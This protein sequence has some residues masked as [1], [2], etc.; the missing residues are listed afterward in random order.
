[1]PEGRESGQFLMPTLPSAVPLDKLVLFGFD[2]RAFPFQSSVQTHLIPGRRPRYVLK[3]GPEGSH[4]PVILY[5]GTVILIGDTFHMWYN[6]N[7]GPT[8]RKCYERKNCVICY[9]TSKD[10]VNWEKPELGLVEFNGSKKNNIVDL[11]APTLWSTCAVMYEPED[12][13]PD[14]RFKMVYEIGGGIENV[15]FSPDGLR[16]TVKG[17]IKLGIEM[18]GLIK[19]RGVYY[20]NGHAGVLSHRPVPGRRLTTYAS[21][22]FE[23]WSPCGVV[24]L[25]RTHDLSGPST[26]ADAHQYEEIHLGAGLWNR[27]NVIIGLYGQW[28]GHF[29]GDR[30]R[31]G[32]DIGLALSYDA[33][34]FH[35]PI[36]DFRFIP[37]REQPGSPQDFG[38]ALMQGQGMENFGDQT[39]YWYSLWRGTP[40]SGIRA[41]TWE[42][43]RIGMLK[44][45]R[46]SG[47]RAISAPIK[48]TE[49]QG[50]VCVNASGL[51]EYSQ[52]RVGLVDEGFNPIPGYSGEDAAVISKSGLC[53]P[54][55]WKAGDSLLPSQGLVRLDIQFAG[56]R[57]EDC[58][59]HV[60]YVG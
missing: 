60:V 6:G 14:R 8:N 1:M 35:E 47:G 33:V 32:I 52:L 55:Q 5:Y 45:F 11:D 41:V 53:M 38:P 50:K 48:V 37:G 18:T 10:G 20:V 43:D 21:T 51:G 44:P 57:P 28:H 12:P 2:D 17:K 30:R 22:D 31:L 59:L 9:A 25:D 15:A 58:R 42:R 16:W 3:H 39:L 54:V 4:D 40:G 24:G 34:H 27:G 26:A 7:Y 56:V 19:F 23:R 36:P 46:E 13:D 29:S 49:G